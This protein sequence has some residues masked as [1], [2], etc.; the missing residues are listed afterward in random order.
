LYHP[1]NFDP[2]QLDSPAEAQ[3]D[4]N[5][6]FMDVQKARDALTSSGTVG[7]FNYDWR[8]GEP[9]TSHSTEETGHDGSDS[10][11]EDE[12]SYGG[13]SANST[14]DEDVSDS[15]ES[16]NNERRNNQNGKGS[17]QTDSPWDTES[18]D[19]VDFGNT[20]GVDIDDEVEET[21]ST[22]GTSTQAGVSRRTAL[23]TL[24]VGGGGLLAA[25]EIGLFGGGNNDG[26]TQGE[27]RVV[28]EPSGSLQE[29]AD[30]VS[31]GGVLEIPSGAHSHNFTI[32]KDMSVVAP[33]GA[34]LVGREEDYSGIMVSDA[35]VK[36]EGLTIV[37]FGGKGIHGGG[38]DQEIT[39]R[40]VTIE[41]TGDVGIELTGSRIDLENVNV[42]GSS[43]TGIE[44]T[45][46]VNGTVTITGLEVTNIQDSNFGNKTELRGLVVD[47]G[48]D[49]V[50]NNIEIIGTKGENIHIAGPA[51]PDAQSI[52]LQDVFVADSSDG[53]IHIPGGRGE[54][55]VVFQNI[56]VR[57]NEYEG[58]V[59]GDENAVNEVRIEDAVIA[60]NND[61]G[62]D[63]AVSQTGMFRLVGAELN[64]NEDD[65][66]GIATDGNGI[67]VQ[68]GEDVLIQDV[69]ITES[70]RDNVHI[71]GEYVE[72]QTVT[73]RS[74]V[75]LNS[76]SGDGV[77]VENS[78]GGSEV[79]IEDSRSDDNG[80]Y[81][82]N[83]GGETIRIT[84]TN[85]SGNSDGA[86]N[87]RDIDREDADIQ[88]SF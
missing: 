62:I 26:T 40:D 72:G 64:R 75:S 55:S 47:S 48:S 6:L 14:S 17:D 38:T 66:V 42:N 71:L 33:E 34:T 81:G 87:L 1:D 49:V 29:A 27:E 12:S 37:D 88:N 79:T 4:A 45:S 20:V 58:V 59:I 57:D 35:N 69:T 74:V 70:G 30:R 51:S 36:I 3:L 41:D 80:D 22:Q 2:E 31:P 52:E 11:D 76:V 25:R 13:T 8:S 65:G 24:G 86:L 61:S 39:L 18:R 32:N 82:F 78:R 73:L 50:L 46:N 60:D 5:K 77:G 9:V 15:N 44:L 68:G 23:I 84:G 83:I 56:E 7:S 43:E 21:V 54:D 63:A 53:G 28:F 85:A 10:P 16:G 67:R 19:D